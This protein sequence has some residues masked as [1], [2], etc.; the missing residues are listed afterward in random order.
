MAHAEKC[1]V[2]EGRGL[3]KGPIKHKDAVLPPMLTCH[4]CGG[5]GWVEVRDKREAALGEVRWTP[6]K[7]NRALIWKEGTQTAEPE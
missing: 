3:V 7:Y 6:D 2:C 4:G 5:T 1:P